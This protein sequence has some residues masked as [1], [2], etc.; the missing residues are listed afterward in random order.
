MAALEPSDPLTGSHSRFPRRLHGSG[1][2]GAAA[3]EI[4]PPHGLPRMAA[5]AGNRRFG[6]DP[7]PRRSASEGMP[8]L[9]SREGAFKRLG[10]NRPLKTPSIRRPLRLARAGRDSGGTRPPLQPV[11][12]GPPL[13]RDSSERVVRI[14]PTRMKAG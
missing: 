1:G 8:A 4:A 5:S 13:R 10:Q 9:V 6:R 12:G 2:N 14:A 7:H 11:R 3:R